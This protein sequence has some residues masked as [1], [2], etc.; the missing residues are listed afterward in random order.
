MSSSL[1]FSP[2]P[3]LN[4]LVLVF[5]FFFFLL[6]LY[7]CALFLVFPCSAVCRCYEL[8][9]ETDGFEVF[10]TAAISIAERHGRRYQTLLAGL[11]L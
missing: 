10:L 1:I 4:L 3:L 11:I 2:H 8:Q 5:F 9:N 6:L 7:Y